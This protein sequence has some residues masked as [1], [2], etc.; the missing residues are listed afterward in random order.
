MS[1][2]LLF[3]HFLQL[4][5]AHHILL[6]TSLRASNLHPHLRLNVLT[7]RRHLFWS[8]EVDRRRENKVLIDHDTWM[9]SKCELS[10]STPPTEDS[11]ICERKG[12]NWK[13]D[14][15]RILELLEWRWMRLMWTRV[16][17][18]SVTDLV[19]LVSSRH[20]EMTVSTRGS[21]LI[22]TLALFP[23]LERV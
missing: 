13:D 23:F 4:C 9:I 1:Q 8:T 14:L 15:V 18:W 5:D 19:S 20:P 17:V 16:K 22:L 7:S 2:L 21:I 12:K 11:G 10:G 3:M 6:S